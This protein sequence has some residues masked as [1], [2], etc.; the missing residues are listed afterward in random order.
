M[1]QAVGRRYVRHVNDMS[2]RTGTLWEG[3][4]KSSLVDGDRYVLAC[5]RYIELNPVRAGMVVQ[6]GD[7][8]WSSHGSNALGQTDLL[9]SPHPVYLQIAADAAEHRAHY[10][11]LVAQGIAADELAIRLYIQRQRALGSSRFQQQ[12]EQ[13]LERRAGI[14]KPGRPRTTDLG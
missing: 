11:T 7:Y 2:G 4:Y 1:M 6:P 9:L 8:P 14:G 13:Q 3:R 10:R 12:V 5:H